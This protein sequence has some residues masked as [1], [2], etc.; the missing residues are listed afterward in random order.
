M[1]IFKLVLIMMLGWVGL[2]GAA[3]QTEVLP[4]HLTLAQ[5]VDMASKQNAQ[6]FA[7][8]ERVR[9]AVANIALSR[10]AFFPQITGTFGGKRQTEDLRASGIKFPG[11]P[12]IGPFNS[13]DTRG[14]LTLEI[15]DPQVIERLSAAK[16]GEKLSQAQFGK[17]RQDILALVGALYLEAQRAAQSVDL[18]KI[19]V[20][21]AQHN[22]QVIH[23]R[24]EQGLGSAS[25]LKK[26]DTGLALAMY[27]FKASEF[28]AQQSRL[29]LASALRLPLDQPM[30]FDMDRDWV[31]REIK[32]SSESPD[33]R[34]ASAQLD[35]SK[36]NVKEA[37]AGFWP[38][39]TA[40]GDY[41]R[42][43]ESPST[44][45]NT[46]SFGAMVSVP[47][48]QG[49]SQQAQLKVARSQVKE[50]Q[51]LL[52]DAKNQDQVKIQEAQNNV[53][54]AK[55]LL[56]VKVDEAREALHQWQVA[57]NR[58]ETGLGSPLELDEA[59]AQKALAEDAQNEAQAMW[60]T[61]KINLARA[62]GRVEGLFES[63]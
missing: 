32:K 49:G 51:I 9:Q 11:D 16:A 63:K 20:K 21:Q 19:N 8:N 34:L 18:N 30:V 6:I 24:L 46:Y 54:Q 2:A 15:F 50:N 56:I 10:S 35:Q 41:G 26:A 38:R 33:V 22:Y 55:S 59:W 27:A 31:Y 37:R 17:L 4:L 47:I 53:E 36:A 61:A 52:E 57:E 29:D 13:F 1:K 7:A 44:A 25:D 14:R 39:L 48:W 3:E 40:S 45:S 42:S 5:A 58:L 43:G 62:M 23:K 28:H 12:H 60:W